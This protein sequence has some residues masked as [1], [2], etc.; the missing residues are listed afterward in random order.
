MSTT[1][2]KETLK[3]LREGTMSIEVKTHQDT[4]KPLPHAA[5]HR[6][7]RKAIARIMT[8]LIQRGERCK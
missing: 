7:N 4:N 8:I 5:M 3:K 1:E 6:E 2:L